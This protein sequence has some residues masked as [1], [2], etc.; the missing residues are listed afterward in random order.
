MKSAVKVSA[1]VEWARRRAVLKVNKHTDLLVQTLLKC[2]E[3]GISLVSP[4]IRRQ[5][6]VKTAD[7]NG[8]VQPSASS[9]HPAR[10]LLDLGKDYDACKA[11]LCGQ[12]RMIRSA[13]QSVMT[14]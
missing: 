4:S 12:K 3:E 2:L 11:Y 1:D 9:S 7:E 14:R 10:L 8:D 6:S 13:C 5:S